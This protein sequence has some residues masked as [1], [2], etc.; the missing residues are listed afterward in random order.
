ML[1]AKI[2]KIGLMATQFTRLCQ[3]VQISRFKCCEY[4]ETGSMDKT[5]LGLELKIRPPPTVE[6]SIISV[7]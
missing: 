6:N 1:Q 3:L 5:S 2:R 7:N 4:A